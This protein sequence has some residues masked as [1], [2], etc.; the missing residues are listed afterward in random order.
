MAIEVILTDIEGTTSSISF[1]KE[2]L[3]PYADREMEAFLRTHWERPAVAECVAQARAESGQPL[4][5]PE[6]AAA[7]FRGWIAEDRKITSLK[8]L[9]GMIWQTGY[10]NGD[11]QAHMY[12]DAVER[13]RQWQA[14]GLKLYV[15]SSGSIAAQKL[16]FGHSVAGDLTPLFSGYYDTTSGGKKDADSYRGITADIGVAPERVLFLS[17]VEAELDAA[18]EAGLNTTLLDREKVLR[19]S[20]HARAETFYDIEL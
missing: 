16:F 3:F 12:S 5:S 8:T 11:Y 14:R 1:V 17:D 13:L 20:P 19:N 6:Q 10:E 7:L 4:A 9:Q 15:Y 2:V 18:R